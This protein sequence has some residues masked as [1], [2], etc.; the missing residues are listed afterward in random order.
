LLKGDEARDKENRF[1][2]RSGEN[3]AL[4]FYEQAV[5]LDPDFALAWAM[6][7]RE[8]SFL[9]DEEAPSANLLATRARQA[10][11]R[12]VGLAP[13]RPE[14]YI[15]LGN[16]ELNVTGDYPRGLEDYARGLS[17]SPGNADLLMGTGAA[18]S[19]LGRWEDAVAHLRQA[20]RVDPRDIQKQLQ[21]AN[22]LLHVRRY[23][24][25][26][27]ACDR[28]LGLRPAYV[29]LLSIKITAFVGEGDAAG[30][31]GVLA[32]A[33]K[34]AESD[35]VA[36]VAAQDLSWLLDDAQR[37]L[38]LR[39][40]PSAFDD[41]ASDWALCLAGAYAIRGDVANTRTYAETARKAIELQLQTAP[42]V[43]VLHAGLGLALAYLGRRV[44][45]IKEGE[46]AVAHPPRRGSGAAGLKD[47]LARIYILVGEQEKALDQLAQLL[48]IPYFLSA[49]WLRIDPNFDPLRN[50]PRFQ[51]LVAGGK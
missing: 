42:D 8:C 45:A 46:L 22:A 15:A 2:K 14:G 26:R 25:A 29:D 49:G 39:L 27:E 47:G 18:E 41:Q 17:S 13:N 33:P 20:E 50:N 37:D 48:Q 19:Y 5:A 40:T 32:G 36:T 24:E 51:K 11:D 4:G 28:G 16:Y 31:R 10:A 7:S 38:L 30:A 44:E 43:Q 1:R 35:L 21:L 6:L 12:A 3:E 34:E 23:R 9:Y